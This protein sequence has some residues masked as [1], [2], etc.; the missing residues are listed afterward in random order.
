MSACKPYFAQV[1]CYIK[2]AEQACF[3]QTFQQGCTNPGRQV[4]RA[5][6]VCAAAPNIWGFSRWHLLHITHLAPR[7]LR[8]LLD[9]WK[10]LCTPGFLHTELQD[11]LALFPPL[12]FAR[13]PYYYCWLHKVSQREESLRMLFMAVSNN[14]VGVWI[15]RHTPQNDLQ[16]SALF[17]H[18]SQALLSL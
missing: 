18:F 14:D 4:T 10:N 7:I 5:T 15:R 12:E 8:W 17:Q 9:F 16:I 6:K 13:L 1:A 2:N 11:V 3:T